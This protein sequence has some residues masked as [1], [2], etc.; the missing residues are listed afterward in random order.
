MFTRPLQFVVRGIAA[1]AVCCVPAFA[2]V[3]ITVSITGTPEEMLPILERLRELGGP[4]AAKAD[5]L[6]LELQSTVVQ[7]DPSAP[8]PAPAPDAPPVPAPAPEPAAA[9]PGVTELKDAKATPA[10]VKP[11]ESALITVVVNDPKHRID[12]LGGVVVET[13]KDNFDLYDD[14][15]H[16]DA[17]AGDN[18]WS[19]T[20][21]T[22]ANVPAGKLTY[23][24]TAFDSNGALVMQDPAE[25]APQALRAE[26]VVE[27]VK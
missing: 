7:P 17:K 1:A 22:G 21:T 14:G 25:G 8:A 24:I 12:T 11:G 26:A 5:A 27:I 15:T 3:Q 9:A 19:Y 18:T 16:G 13:G 23:Q 4:A 2:D 20:L 10:A 6:K